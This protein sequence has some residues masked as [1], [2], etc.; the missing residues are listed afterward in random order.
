M[1]EKRVLVTGACGEMGQALVQGLARRGGY[2]IVTS[3]LAPASR[4]HQDDVVRT[5]AGGSDIQNQ[6]FL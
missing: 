1:T 3:D 6:N 5:C 4:G 2:R